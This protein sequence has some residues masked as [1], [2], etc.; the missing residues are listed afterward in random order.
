MATHRI[1]ILGHATVPDDSGEVF[2]QPLD[3]ITTTN[4]RWPALV[5]TFND[6]STRDGLRGRF[7]VPQNY[8]GGSKIVVNWSSP[9]I[10]N[11][12]VWDFEYRAVA[13]GENL[14]QSGQDQSL[15]VTDTAPDTAHEIRYSNITL[16]SGN[17][18]PGSEVQ[19]EFFRDGADAADDLADVVYITSLL[20]EYTDA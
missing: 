9:A 3:L 12:V 20:F 17:F 16:A 18:A 19:Y 14:D 10:T 11:E 2:L 8:V 13:S 4:D 7:V 5:F 1:T 15:T 6:T